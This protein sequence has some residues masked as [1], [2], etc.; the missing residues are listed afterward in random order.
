SLAAFGATS[1]YDVLIRGI[2][3][4]STKTG[5]KALV[6]FTDGE[7]QGSQ[8]SLEQVE[9]RLQTNDVILYMIG[10]GRGVELEALKK[11]M[12]RLTQPTG[13][14]ALFTNRIEELRGAF[15]DLLTEISHQ[16]LLAYLPSNS[17]RDNRWRRIRVDVDGHRQIR[18]R[19]GY[20]MTP[21]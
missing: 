8:A 21:Q 10:Q 11:S 5:R 18:A 6:V 12:R 2:D 7:D 3:L 17:T 9:Q 1:L 4:M 20:R 19:E 15:S 16:Y 13:G 14:R